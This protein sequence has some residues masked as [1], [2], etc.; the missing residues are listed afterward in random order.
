MLEGAYFKSSQ[1]RL[2]AD[3]R[4]IAAF[5]SRHIVVRGRVQ[6]LGARPAVFRLAQQCGLTGTVSNTNLGLEI[7]VEGAAEHV[8]AFI[9]VLPRRFPPDAVIESIEIEKYALRGYDQF[10]ISPSRKNS[11]SAV[12]VP[13]DVCVCSHCLCEVDD[14][15]NPRHLYPFTNCTNC[16]PRYSLLSAMPYD[17]AV[18]SMDEFEMCPRCQ[19]EYCDSRDRRF[20]SQTN[21]CPQCGPR[22]WLNGPDGETPQKGAD[23]MQV[24]ADALTAGQIVALRGVGGY[25]LL[26]DATSEQT[27]RELRNR[28]GRAGKPF[29]VLV[30]ESG[31]ARQL[32]KLSDDE[33]RVLSG[34]VNPIVLALVSEQ[35]S[36]APSIAPGMRTVGLMM[37]TTP[38]HAQLVKR[39][40]RPLVV[41]SANREGEP[42]IFDNQNSC[43]LSELADLVLDHNRPI[44]R[45][46]DDSVVGVMAGRTATI[47]LGR[48]LAPLP[49]DVT[50][51]AHVLALGGHQKAAIALS[52][53]SQSI[54]GPH[55]GDLDGESTRVRFIEHVKAMCGLYEVEPEFV[56][57]DEHPDYFTTCWAQGLGLPSLAV[58]HHHAHVVA[59]MLEPHWLD[60][61]VLGVAWDGSGYGPDGTIW[62]GEFLLATSAGYERV[63]TLRPFCL[64]G[65]EHAVRQPWRVGM[66]LL[67]QLGEEGPLPALFKNRGPAPELLS[68]SLAG[69]YS[70]P[71]TTSAG[72]LF[73]GV[74]ALVLGI[75]H[76]DFEGQAAM[77]LES[78]CDHDATGQ[79]EIPL[80]PGQ[81][82]ELD[83]R[84]LLRGVLDDLRRGVPAGTIAMRFH[85]ALADG[86]VAIAMGFEALPIVLCGGCFY[87]RVLTEL[88]VERLKR[89]GRIVAAPGTIPIGDG[90]LAAG[91][92]AIAAARLDN[93][94]RS[95]A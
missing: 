11:R 69:D 32:G 51:T 78:A 55:I 24:A 87:N 48:G 12:Q 56:V 43:Q 91:Q 27:V 83:W 60:R 54:L 5:V 15:K 71:R 33:H 10:S 21:C 13:P 90:G 73:D 57:H 16:G 37:P 17:R 41:T 53:G 18:T 22:I 72:R 14:A 93:G 8:Q 62:G 66:A 76:V 79:Y 81:P 59:A 88:A 44:V 28:K 61:C 94:A 70:W 3:Q 64:P 95:C 29:A 35:S 77:L 23:A 47:R 2:P 25:Q 4:S 84:P 19:R 45:P 7:Q 74:A 92:I 82:R 34:P 1:Q 63:G 40:R 85:R 38:L 42:L 46:V 52:N 58:Q 6:G 20:H 80:C 26:A 89:I 50:C 65:G 30:S 31:C 36:L 9:Q 67:H 68:K 75:E 86:I 39:S 49:L